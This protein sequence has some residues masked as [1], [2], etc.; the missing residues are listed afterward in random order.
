M[1]GIRTLKELNDKSSIEE[2]E[3]SHNIPDAYP[4]LGVAIIN[5]VDDD[6]LKDAEEAYAE[7]MQLIKRVKSKAQKARLN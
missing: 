5:L 2:F 6:M 3:K 4:A 1:Y 7:L